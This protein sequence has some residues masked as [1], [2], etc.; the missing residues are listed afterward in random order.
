MSNTD[1]L[2]QLDTDTSTTTRYAPIYNL[3]ILNDDDHSFPYVV[4][5]LQKVF[6]MDKKKADQITMHIHEKGEAI[7][8]TNA[9][10]Y[11]ELKQEQVKTFGPDVVATFMKKRNIDY[12]LGSRIEECP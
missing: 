9:L 10:E 12:P 8:C 5:L 1:T 2:E 6:R 3:I 7:V 11:V 4:E